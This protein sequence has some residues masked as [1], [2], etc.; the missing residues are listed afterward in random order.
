MEPLPSRNFI[1]S[2]AAFVI[3]CVNGILLLLQQ[4]LPTD[5][6]TTIKGSPPIQLI[7][8]DDSNP[9]F[10]SIQDNN[11]AWS[12]AA[13]LFSSF[14]AFG[15]KSFSFVI[16]YLGF[17]TSAC[18]LL[19]YYFCRY[20]NRQ[21]SKTTPLVDSKNATTHQ[22]SNDK[23]TTVYVL[24][25][26]DNFSKTDATKQQPT[27][28]PHIKVGRIQRCFNFIHTVYLSFC[29]AFTPNNTH[30]QFP[31]IEMSQSPYEVLNTIANP[32]HNTEFNSQLLKDSLF[33]AATVKT[34]E[35]LLLFL[36]DSIHF[37]SLTEFKIWFLQQT[38]IPF[39]SN[40]SLAEKEHYFNKQVQ[41][42]L[43]IVFTTSIALT[44]QNLQW[45]LCKWSQLH[46]LL[47][48]KASHLFPLLEHSV[49]SSH[50]WLCSAIR[51]I[52][53]KHP[54]IDFQD[55]LFKLANT[56]L[57]VPQNFPCN[58]APK[59]SKRNLADST[60]SSASASLTVRWVN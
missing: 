14:V 10:M 46:Y 25:Y 49:W 47:G 50:P 8:T 43:G 37:T 39:I 16:H 6:L 29:A 44:L 40:P 12:Y 9:G 32:L 24:N 35:R 33:D 17:K 11:N 1:P 20:M 15:C 3:Y 51:K 59:Q 36:R 5:F 4:F 31:A 2:A 18:C 19:V 34:H 53:M 27:P 7:T 38:K 41:K 56:R 26:V 58:S 45:H 13:T 54:H 21:H 28:I 48:V 52:L 42:A 55:L 60:N 22:F 30:Y 23:L 57:I